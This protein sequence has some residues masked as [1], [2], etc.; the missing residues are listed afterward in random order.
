[1]TKQLGHPLLAATVSFALGSL[2]LMLF[3]VVTANFRK[4]IQKTG[5]IYKTPFES[6]LIL[7]NK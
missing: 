1:L 4:I 3:T 5:R 2:A 6:L 7:E